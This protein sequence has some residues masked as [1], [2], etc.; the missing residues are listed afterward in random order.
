MWELMK[1]T[2]VAG[3]GIIIGFAMGYIIGSD[4]GFVKGCNWAR[5]NR[6]EKL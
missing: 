1:L 2:A 4:N 5:Y 6:E 3:A